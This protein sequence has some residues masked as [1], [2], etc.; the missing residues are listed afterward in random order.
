VI[1]NGPTR[2]LL[3]DD[4]PLQRQA[5]AA[6]LD[7]S[8]D[9][10]TAATGSNVQQVRQ[11]LMRMHPDVIV[12]DLELR[13]ADPFDLLRKLRGHYPVPLIVV[14]PAT[15][16]GARHALRATALGALEVVRRPPDARGPAITAFCQDLT[17]VIQIAV[18]GARPLPRTLRPA[19]HTSSFRA[20]GVDPR[21]HVI[22]IGAST[23]GTEAVTGLLKRVPVDCP[24]VVIVQHMPPGF[25]RS[26]AERLNGLSPM[27]VTEAVDGEALR[28]GCAIIARGDTH[29]T[30]RQAGNGWV[31][32]YTDKTLVNHHCP[33]VD[34]LFESVAKSAGPR[35]AGVL[36]TG[37]G[38]DGAVGLLSMRRSGAITVAQTE[39]TC[40]VYGMPKEAIA[41]GAAMFSAAPEDVPGVL[42]RAMVNRVDHHPLARAHA[43]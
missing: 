32:R 28:E 21:R 16:A 7:R 30:L 34:V 25:T 14:A 1:T 27:R 5:L 2:I 31:A 18:S 40:V 6:E 9:L 38:A 10:H 15:D 11:S 42:L 4:A 17:R 37:M 24:P 12:M 29:L 43:D 26:F 3:I 33:S 36:L 22:A 13:A 20:A 35:A 23:G 19:A 8:A 39:A 41:L